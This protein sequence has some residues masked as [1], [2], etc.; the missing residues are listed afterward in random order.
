MGINL[1][2]MRFEMA[3]SKSIQ[4]IVW[5]INSLFSAGSHILF[6]W[7][8]IRNFF[9]NHIFQVWFIAINS[10]KFISQDEFVLP[11]EQSPQSLNADNQGVLLGCYLRARGSSEFA[12]GL[13]WI[14]PYLLSHRI[15]LRQFGSSAL[16]NIGDRD[17]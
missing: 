2:C 3:A 16:V 13:V 4:G 9:F 14:S 5:E 10:R 8:D 6:W 12:V 7:G 1:N 17:T 11:G 15:W